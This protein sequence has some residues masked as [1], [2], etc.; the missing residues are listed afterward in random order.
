MD[1]RGRKRAAGGDIGLETIRFPYSEFGVRAQRGALMRIVHVTPMYFP[2]MGGAEWHAQRLS[3]CLASRG[4]DV[5][6]LTS[7]VGSVWS[8][9]FADLPHREMIRGVRVKRLHP[10]GGRLGKL[11]SA[12]QN[13]RGGYRSAQ[14]VLG[15]DGAS[16]ICGHPA[17]FQLIPFLARTDADVVGVF[18]WRWPPAYH[19]YLARKWKRFT[20]VAIPLFHPAEEWAHRSLHR[21][22][23]GKCD[24]AIANTAYEARF[25]V[26]FA[27]IP[28]EVA[29]V[30]V[31]PARYENR[32]GLEVRKRYGLGSFP[33]VGFIGRQDSGKGADTVLRAMQIVWKTNR[34]ARL[35]MAGFQPWP[36]RD[37]EALF[38][39][40]SNFE[41]ERLVRIRNF[42]EEEKASIFDAVDVFAMPSLAESFGIAYLDAWMCGKPVIGARIGPTECVIEENRDG[43]LVAPRDPEDTARAILDLLR[44][45]AKREELGR[46][47][48]RKAVERFTWEKVAERVEKFYTA[49]RVSKI[50]SSRRLA[51]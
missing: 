25:M 6:V 19:A 10:Q 4:H 28:I 44:N 47:G 22:M 30:G 48:R 31:D 14:W 18:N 35:L 33:V 11:V 45:P 2:A 1:R 36:D 21:K 37:L 41:R 24:G 27:R 40:L 34:E 38:Q 43:L 16:L 13:L 8:R 51:A 17:L 50:G 29:G 23:L 49:V 5:T 32:N 42:A 3:E 39:G 12:W 15:G 7:N 26:E 46:S 20:L 9:T